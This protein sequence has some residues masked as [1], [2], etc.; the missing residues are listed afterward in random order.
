[1]WYYAVLDLDM[2]A[3]VD[4]I[5]K[6]YQKLA[7]QTHPDRTHG[8]GRLFGM[9]NEAYHVL[10]NPTSRFA[11]DRQCGHELPVPT[12]WGSRVTPEGRYYYYTF[13]DKHV[14]FQ[15]PLYRGVTKVFV[16]T[17]GWKPSL[18][19]RFLSASTGRPLRWR[20]THGWQ[21]LLPQGFFYAG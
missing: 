5:K 6:Q 11:Y 4:E 2:S 17:C 10:C 20:K 1:M 19:E 16:K 18:P 3:S 21:R 12:G 7:L 14:Q 15:H 9:I 13:Q 8:S